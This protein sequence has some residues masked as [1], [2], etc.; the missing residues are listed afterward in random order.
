M[1][2]RVPSGWF[3]L[4]LGAILIGMGLLT[5]GTAPL[6]DVN[7]NLYCGFVMALFGGWMLWLS[8]RAS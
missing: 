2:L 1:D 8:K 4:L 3:F 5:T 7:V 6:S